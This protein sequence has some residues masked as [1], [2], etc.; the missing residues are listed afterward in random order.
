MS[1]Y[2]KSRVAQLAR[3]V[4]MC[5]NSQVTRPVWFTAIGKHCLDKTMQSEVHDHCRLLMLLR[6]RLIV[7]SLYTISTQQHNARNVSGSHSECF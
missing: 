2:A 1:H 3:V 5:P 7:V 6:I 4:T